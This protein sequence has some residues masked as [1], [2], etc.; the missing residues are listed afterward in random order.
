MLAGRWGL[1][2]PVD[3][4]GQDQ[5][6][7]LFMQGVSARVEGA[8]RVPLSAQGR[9]L[10]FSLADAGAVPIVSQRVA[11]LLNRLTPRD[12]EL[13]PVAVE[14]YPEPYFLVN[15]VR[16]VKCI[17]D[18]ASGEVRYWTPEDGRPDRVGTYRAVHD[19]RIDPMKTEGADI[20]RTWGW[21]LA[22]IISKDIKLALEHLGATGVRFKDVSPLR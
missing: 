13:F 4:Q 1:G 9:A 5:G 17:D 12:V 7:W 18:A 10:D 16:L 2:A 8:L 22:L 21:P 15:V 6:S 20:F 3:A 19:L 14:G 11:E